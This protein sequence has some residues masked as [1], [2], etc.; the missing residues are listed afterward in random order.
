MV[1]DS[2]FDYRSQDARKLSSQL[3]RQVF[4]DFGIRY[5]DLEWY[6]LNAVPD[7]VVRV[8][9]NRPVIAVKVDCT[10]ES[11]APS[12]GL[13]AIDIGRSPD[14]MAWHHP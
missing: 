6:A 10:S 1:E 13:I 14:E 4:V 9:D 12:S 11:A 8:R 5:L 2:A 7:R 3:R